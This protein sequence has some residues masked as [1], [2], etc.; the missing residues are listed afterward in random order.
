MRSWEDNCSF[1]DPYYTFPLLSSARRF[2]L[3]VFDLTGVP[4]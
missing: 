4:F 2:E 1:L 3:K